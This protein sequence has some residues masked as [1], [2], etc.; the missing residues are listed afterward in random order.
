MVLQWLRL[1]A[2]DLTSPY[3][4]VLSCRWLQLVQLSVNWLSVMLPQ[5]GQKTSSNK[6]IEFKFT[7]TSSLKRIELATLKL[8]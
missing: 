7:S 3:F 4:F 6:S 5:A 1:T 8:A 2:F